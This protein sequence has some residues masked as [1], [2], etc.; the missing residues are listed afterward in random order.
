MCSSWG[1]AWN[2]AKC[3]R[4]L[5]SPLK[6]HQCT[7]CP[8][9]S[10][11]SRGSLDLPLS[12]HFLHIFWGN[13]GRYLNQ[14]RCII[15]PACLGSS[16]STTC[17]KHLTYEAFCRHLSEAPELNSMTYYSIVMEVSV[18]LSDLVLDNLLLVASLKANWS[19]VRGLTKT[20]TYRPMV[21]VTLPWVGL[22]GPSWSLVWKRP[23]VKQIKAS[24]WEQWTPFLLQRL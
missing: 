3:K 23:A 24:F 15:S 18:W 20:L 8:G 7:C 19:W 5:S 13:I 6:I 4:I 9:G 16:P 14:L 10:S 22:L 11:P 21:Q 12:S 17:M 2:A 1:K